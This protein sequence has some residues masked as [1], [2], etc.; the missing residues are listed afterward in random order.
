[1]EAAH[2]RAD[3]LTNQEARLVA[4][5][6]LLQSA[7]GGACGAI[8]GYAGPNMA[9]IVRAT[10]LGADQLERIIPWLVGVDRLDRYV[11]EVEGAVLCCAAAPI[12]GATV[13]GFAALVGDQGEVWGEAALASVDQIAGLLGQAASPVSDARH[14]ADRLRFAERALARQECRYRALLQASGEG[15]V[16]QSASGAIIEANDEAC[17][18]LALSEDQLYGRT[19]LHPDWGAVDQAGRPLAGDQH[20][21]M[22]A[23]ST[24]RAV[25]DFIMGID[26]PGAGRRWIFVNATP[27]CEVPGA[28]SAVVAT[29]RQGR[30]T[31][32]LA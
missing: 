11:L 20:P 28:P 24:G 10:G 7:H 12:V 29:F 1:M 2:G 31:A 23:L 25:R 30:W 14:D 18:I 13:A 4:A 32:P 17:R 15:V 19:S 27:V 8:I 3:A 16:V 5:L 21:A 26:A 22:I 9:L 6:S